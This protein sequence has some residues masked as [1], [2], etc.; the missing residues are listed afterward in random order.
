[1]KTPLC[2]LAEIPLDSAIKVDLFG[3]EALVYLVDRRPRAVANVCMHLGGPLAQQ[4]ERFV[5]AWHGATFSCRDGKKLH[6]PGR[7][8]ARLM[9]LP[10]RVEG[11]TLYYVWDE[12]AQPIAEGEL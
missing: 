1:M 4:G 11:E 5:C 3:R 7:P 12:P 8:G 6:G 10:T 2:S 9:T